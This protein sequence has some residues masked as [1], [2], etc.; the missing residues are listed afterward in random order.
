MT[1]AI[2][3][4]GAQSGGAHV[5]QIAAHELDSWERFYFGAVVIG[6]I[7]PTESNGVA[8]EGEDPCIV[9][10]GASDVSAEIFNRGSS[11][12]GGLD[13]NSPHFGPDLGIDLPTV[14]F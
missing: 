13:M 8:S 3:A 2:V 1:K 11:G 6:T 5:T 7:F 10:G 9:D 12:A 14:L 4:D